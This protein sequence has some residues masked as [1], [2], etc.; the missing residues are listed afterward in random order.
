MLLN[1]F[2]RAP[3]WL[4]QEVSMLDF[5]GTLAILSLTVFMVAALAAAADLPLGARLVAAGVLALWAGFAAA[6]AAAGWIAIARPPVIGFY[7][8]APLIAGA[9]FARRA[10]AA[11]PL[12]AMVGLNIGRALGF[13]FLLLAAD[14]RLSG[15][16]PQS[17]GWG[18]VITGLVAVPMVFLAREPERNA[19]ALQAWNLF[20]LADLIAAIALGVAS[21]N[22]GL[23]QLF[24]APGSAAMQHLPW[25]LIPTVLVP[26]YMV[27]HGAMFVRLQRA[28]SPSRR[29]PG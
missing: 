5:A 28:L 12:Q 21:A 14:G 29:A 1:I 3:R 17:A 15:P 13:L 19:L 8:A 24:P 6:S 7:V 4:Q 10:L 20:G 25:S 9:L 11:L 23:L 2:Y 22:G 26:V 16:F 27:L 18:D